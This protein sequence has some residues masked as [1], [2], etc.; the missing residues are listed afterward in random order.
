MN[1]KEL[2]ESVKWSWYDVLGV[3]LFFFITLLLKENILTM[4][5]FLLG[6]VKLIIHLKE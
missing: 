4:L 1:R 5:I 3:Q 6:I 2:E